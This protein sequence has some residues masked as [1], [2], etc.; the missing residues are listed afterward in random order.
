MKIIPKYSTLALAIACS[1][2]ISVTERA[3]AQNTALTAY[4]WTQNCQNRRGGRGST[5]ALMR[6]ANNLTRTT[7]R[8]SRTQ[9]N[10]QLRDLQLFPRYNDNHF[11][12][13]RALNDLRN[14]RIGTRAGSNLRLKRWESQRKIDLVQMGAIYDALNGNASVPG[15]YSTVRSGRIEGSTSV[16]EHGHNYNGLHGLAHRFLGGRFTVMRSGAS[17]RHNRFSNPSVRVRGTAQGTSRNNNAKRIRDRRVTNAN[18][19]R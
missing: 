7:H 9:A 5:T 4:I 17:N 14:G 15:A 8:I 18:R 2:N 16:H 19:R 1:L 3:E 10:L 11:N 12:P 6:R 13:G